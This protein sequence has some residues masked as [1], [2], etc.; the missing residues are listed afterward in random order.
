MGRCLE[1]LGTLKGHVDPFSFIVL[2]IYFGPSYLFLIFWT[3]L[4]FSFFCCVVTRKAC[5]HDV[6]FFWVP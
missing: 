1:S 4:F 3:F 6:F 2:F 5:N